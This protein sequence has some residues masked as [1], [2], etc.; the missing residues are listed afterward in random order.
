MKTSPSVKSIAYP[1][2]VVLGIF[3]ILNLVL[4]YAFNVQ[5]GNWIMGI[6]NFVITFAIFTM[7]IKTYRQNNQGFLSIKGALKMGLAVAVIGGLIAAVYA[8][9]HYSY[10]SPEY[11]ELIREDA[12]VQISE[13]P[14]QEEQ[15]EQAIQ[16]TNITTSPL[17]FAT[18]TLVSSLF[19]GFLISLIIGAI[20]KSNRAY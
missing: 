18:I 6:I 10:V 1:Y 17:F 9:I 16:I 5:Q 8:F 4:L 20:M 15:R 7:A 14:L 11:I 3:S 2:G 12:F 13:Q 19:F